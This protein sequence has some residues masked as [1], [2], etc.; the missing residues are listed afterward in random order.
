MLVRTRRAGELWL[1]FTLWSSTASAVLGL[2][3]HLQSKLALHFPYI[4]VPPLP[5]SLPLPL[6]PP[7]PPPEGMGVHEM[8]TE[9]EF[10]PFMKN[11]G[12]S[13]VSF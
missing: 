3:N 6:T 9:E 11:S 7:S 5:P 12:N 13:L 4:I 10:C 2:Q 1:L 8:A